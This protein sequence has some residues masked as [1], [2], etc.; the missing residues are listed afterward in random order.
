MCDICQQI[1]CHPRCP[2]AP[3]PPVVYIC[4]GCGCDIYDGDDYWD[5]LGEQ[6]CE[7]CIDDLRRVA[8]YDPY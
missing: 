3:D 4:S 8:E 1:P 7:N 5:I 6:F 2:Y